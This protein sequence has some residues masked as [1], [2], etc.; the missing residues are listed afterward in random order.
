MRTNG[1][2]TAKRP[3]FLGIC[4][5]YGAAVQLHHMYDGGLPSEQLQELKGIIGDFRGR[6]RLGGTLNLDSLRHQFSQRHRILS[7]Y[8]SRGQVLVSAQQGAK[9]ALLSGVYLL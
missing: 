5:L 4:C 8:P 3:C 7:S 2:R 1:W 9:L 6:W